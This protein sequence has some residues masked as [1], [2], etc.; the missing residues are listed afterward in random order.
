MA[1]LSFLA[2]YEIQLCQDRLKQFIRA[3][4]RVTFFGETDNTL[5]QKIGRQTLELNWYMQIV[6][7]DMYLLFL[8][9]LVILIALYFDI[10]YL[11]LQVVKRCESTVSSLS[12]RRLVARSSVL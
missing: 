6:T 12:E 1:Y 5:D 2:G 11:I 7:F 3:R 10:S 4:S 9:S 8:V